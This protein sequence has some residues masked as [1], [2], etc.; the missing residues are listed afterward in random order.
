MSSENTIYQFKVPGL[1][2]GEE[3][4]F[5]AFKGKKILVVNTASQCGLTP[6][7]AG[8]QELHEEFKDKVTVVGMPSNDF[9]GQEPGTHDEIATF[10]ETN[11]GVTFPMTEKVVTKGDDAHPVY[12]WLTDRSKNGVLDAEVE[13]NFHKFLIDEEGRLTH[14]FAA[15]TAP[16][17]EEILDALNG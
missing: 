16:A 1:K 8:L 9:G 13:W 7:Y 12:Q 5:A 6:H 4:D 2:S 15:T 17:S 14:S 3:V 10:C 11:F